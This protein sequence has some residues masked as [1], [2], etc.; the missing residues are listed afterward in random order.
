MPVTL[1]E[2]PVV[3]V[4]PPVSVSTASI[5]KDPALPRDHA[6]VDWATFEAGACVNDC[7]AVVCRRHPEVAEALAALRKLGPAR[8]SGTGAAVFLLRFAT[9]GPDGDRPI[10]KKLDQTRGAGAESFATRGYTARA[11]TQRIR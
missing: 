11:V 1:P 6:R 5:F 8:L 9:R 4:V 7:E 10:A 2:T 3:L